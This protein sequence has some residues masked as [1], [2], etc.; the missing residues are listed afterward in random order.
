VAGVG[1]AGT[2]TEVSTTPKERLPEL[3]IVA[4]EPADSQVRASHLDERI[5]SEL[6]QAHHGHAQALSS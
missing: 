5:P 1:T 3:E 4:V 2:L 6:V